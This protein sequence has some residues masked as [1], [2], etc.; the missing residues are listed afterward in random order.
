MAVVT[1][2]TR[3]NVLQLKV[4]VYVPGSK[5]T[6]SFVRLYQY[7]NFGGPSSALANRS[8]FKADKVTLLW[9]KKGTLKLDC[10]T[11]HVRMEQS[12]YD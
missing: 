3:I 7:P 12:V 4:A 6:P 8:F 10:G 1:R 5:G 11:V 9:N 2:L